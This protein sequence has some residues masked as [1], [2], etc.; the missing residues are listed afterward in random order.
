MWRQLSQPSQEAGCLAPVSGCLTSVIEVGRTLMLG[1]SSA[2]P[3][4][5]V[6]GDQPV[7]GGSQ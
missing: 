4:R 5:V 7:M 1:A 2:S 6:C 3:R